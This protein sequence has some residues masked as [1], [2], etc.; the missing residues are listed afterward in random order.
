MPAYEYHTLSVCFVVFVVFRGAQLE[1]ADAAA[2]ARRLR[3]DDVVATARAYLQRNNGDE[4]VTRKFFGLWRDATP[5][6]APPPQWSECIDDASGVGAAAL[7]GDLRKTYCG[8][9]YDVDALR[10]THTRAAPKR[11]SCVVCVLSPLSAL[12][13]L[14]LSL[15]LSLSSLLCF[16]PR[17]VSRLATRV[18]Q[19]IAVG[20]ASILS[21]VRQNAFTAFISNAT[22]SGRSGEDTTPLPHG[23]TPH[24]DDESGE[25]YYYNESTGVT[26]WER[27]RPTQPSRRRTNVKWKFEKVLQDSLFSF[28]LLLMMSY[29]L[30]F[31]MYNSART[32][33]WRKASL[34][35]EVVRVARR[36]TWRSSLKRYL[37]TLIGA[38][39]ARFLHSNS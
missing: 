37:L 12:R 29:L 6:L 24:L 19:S 15:S 3:E 28:S 7:G 34:E 31:A 26:T 30:Y 36:R 35:R 17:R 13:S 32:S 1:R 21:P 39:Q 11:A 5:R 18:R 38:I 14:S 4:Q 10:E 23:W 22:A 8:S 2:E 27:P 9:S 16:L 25:L 33:R 20:F